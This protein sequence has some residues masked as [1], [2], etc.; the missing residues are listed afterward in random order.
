[1]TSLASESMGGSS[2]R[3]AG[4]VSQLAAVALITT[5]LHSADSDQP[6]AVARAQRLEDGLGALARIKENSGTIRIRTSAVASASVFHLA[7]TATR[8]SPPVHTARDPLPPPLR[9]PRCAVDAR[10]RGSALA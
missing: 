3:W 9:V 5:V 4:A 7:H 10:S 2:V 1:M 6:C 8:P